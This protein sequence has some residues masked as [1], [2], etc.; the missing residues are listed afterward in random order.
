LLVAE[1]MGLLSVQMCLLALLEELEERA[2][3]INP[4][5]LPVEGKA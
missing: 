4:R 3:L 1:L 2:K 5:E